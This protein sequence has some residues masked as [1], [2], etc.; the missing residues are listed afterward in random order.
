MRVPTWSNLI[1]LIDPTWSNLLI[2]L[3]PTWSDS[4]MHSAARMPLSSSTVDT[5]TKQKVGM[6]T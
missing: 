4:H 1:Q 3:D 5:G 6:R 2:Q